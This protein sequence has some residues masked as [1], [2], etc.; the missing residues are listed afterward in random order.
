[1]AF[2]PF[3]PSQP[4]HATHRNL[5]HWQQTGATYFVT[6]RLADSLPASALARVA[7][8]RTL[9]QSA[10][11]AWLDRYLDSGVGTCLFS[12]PTHANLIAS[13]L[14]YFD[15]SRYNL[16]AFAIM[17]NHVHAIMQPTLPHTLTQI[18]HSW[19][20]YTARQLQRIAKIR[21]SIWQ[22]ES[23]DRIIRDEAEFDRI[24]AY[25]LANPATARLRPDTYIVSP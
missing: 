10:T 7:E 21:G 13:T 15:R 8:L 25:I 23:F 11:F 17:P 22:K 14:R 12:Q 24:S 6:F 1:V 4:V 2:Q 5:P 20:S 16:G 18:L 9:N 3:N 19:K